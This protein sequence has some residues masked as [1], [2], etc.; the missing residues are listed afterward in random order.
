MFQPDQDDLQDKLR[1][2]FD[3]RDYEAQ[4]AYELAEVVAKEY[5]WKSLTEQAFAHLV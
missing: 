4:V 3:N 2:H 5:D 1:W